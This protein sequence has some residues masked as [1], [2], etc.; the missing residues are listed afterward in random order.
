MRG[1]GEVRRSAT[2]GLG[3]ITGRGLGIW[4]F[5]DLGVEAGV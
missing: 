4:G 1:L 5:G 2:D 3:L